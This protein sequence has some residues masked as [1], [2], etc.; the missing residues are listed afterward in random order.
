MGGI[1]EGKERSGIVIN[2]EILQEE[3]MCLFW[4]L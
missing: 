4:K 1:G 3:V 2:R